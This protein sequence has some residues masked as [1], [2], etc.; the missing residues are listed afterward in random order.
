MNY[1]FDWIIT[2]LHYL[3]PSSKEHSCFSAPI[4]KFHASHAIV[5]QNKAKQLTLSVANNEKSNA[6]CL[7]VLFSS[8]KRLFLIHRLKPRS[9]H[10]FLPQLLFFF[11]S[12]ATTYLIYEDA[13]KNDKNIPPTQPNP[14]YSLLT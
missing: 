3:N 2:V 6:F 12:L 13:H 8:S 1:L 5:Q 14:N 4:T 7:F 9:R 11:L 10:R